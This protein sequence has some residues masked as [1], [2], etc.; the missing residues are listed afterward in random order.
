ML[1]TKE[2]D[3]LLK[4]VDRRVA[5]AVE[6]LKEE[7]LKPKATPKKESEKKT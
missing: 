1:T 7:L 5:E 4:Q 2:L 6:A 3:Y